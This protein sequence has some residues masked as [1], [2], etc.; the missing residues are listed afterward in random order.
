MISRNVCQRKGIIWDEWRYERDAK[1]GVI[2]VKLNSF[3]VVEYEYQYM[4]GVN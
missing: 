1:S 2:F 3:L 4:K